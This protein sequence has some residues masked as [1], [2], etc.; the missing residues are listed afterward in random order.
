MVIFD[1]SQTVSTT[2]ADLICRLVDH[3]RPQI[4]ASYDLRRAKRLMGLGLV[5]QGRLSDRYFGASDAGSAFCAAFR[6]R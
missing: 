4:L 1:R 6:M 2:E 5:V 3:G